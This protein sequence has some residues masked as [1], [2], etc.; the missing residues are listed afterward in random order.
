M[1]KITW[2]TRLILLGAMAAGMI[3]TASSDRAAAGPLC[4][5][6]ILW[7]CAVPGCPDCPVVIFGGTVCQKEAF[8]RQTGRVCTPE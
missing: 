8:E 5:P 7:S 6:T 3:L 2:Q 1:R 4:G